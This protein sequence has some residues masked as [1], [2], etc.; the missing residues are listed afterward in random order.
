M[1]DLFA[2]PDDATV[3]DPEAQEGLKQSWIITRSDLNQAEQANIQQG[4][5]WARRSRQDILSSDFIRKLH[6]RMLG[7]VWIWAGRFR[8][9]NLN[10][11]IEYHQIPTQL[12]QK[13]DDTRFWVDNAT[14]HPDEIAV[15]L[16]HSLVYIHPFL[17]GNGRHARLMAD[18]LI[19]RLN[20]EVFSWGGKNLTSVSELRQQYIHALKAADTLDIEPLLAFARS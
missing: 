11:G 5:I 16:H 13:L 10:L 15:R 3:L 8:T 4:A 14:Y 12:K 19:A 20:G 2:E 17:N 6:A 1:T 18:L 7:D 9:R